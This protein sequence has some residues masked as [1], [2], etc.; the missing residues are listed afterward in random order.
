MLITSAASM[1]ELG[2]SESLRFS[3][4]IIFSYIAYIHLV[5][6]AFKCYCYGQKETAFD[7]VKI[8]N[9]L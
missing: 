7:Y 4:N 1:Q 8:F 9:L 2:L 5:G 3:M 6:V